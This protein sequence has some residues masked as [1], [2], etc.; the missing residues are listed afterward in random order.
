MSCRTLIQE[1]HTMKTT[2]QVQVH[3]SSDA[4]INSYAATITNELGSERVARSRASTAEWIAAGFDQHG[5]RAGDQAPPFS[6]PDAQGRHVALADLLRKGPVVLTFYRGGWCPYCNVLLRVYQNILPQ[7]NTLGTTLVAV[8]PQLP[9]Y[10]LSTAEKNALSFPVLSDVGNTVAR[11]YGVV[12]TVD[13]ETRERYLGNGND[14]AVINGNDSW[15]LPITGTFI[16]DQSGAIHRAFVNADYTQR[17]EPETLLADLE[18][19]AG[20]T[21]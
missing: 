3:V 8:S 10:T 7:I 13:A 19:L 2:G 21:A 20:Q 18:V 4:S 9:D 16:I 11:A 15:E 6:L 12:F 14:L 17:L 1:I 5:L